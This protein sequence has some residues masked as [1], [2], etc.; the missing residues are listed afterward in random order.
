MSKEIRNSVFLISEG[1]SNPSSGIVDVTDLGIVSSD[2]LDQTDAIRVILEA[3]YKIVRFPAGIYRCRNLYLQD[4]QRIIVNGTIKNINGITFDVTQNAAEGQKNIYI[5]DATT[6]QLNSLESLINEAPDYY[7]YVAF[8]D[9]DY[10]IE[11]G[12]T[13]QVH[14]NSWVSRLTA[15]NKVSKYITV[16]DNIPAM[17]NYCGG[18]LKVSA[19]AKVTVLYNVLEVSAKEDVTILGYGTLDANR[20]NTADVNPVWISGEEGYPDYAGSGANFIECINSRQGKTLTVKD[21]TVQNGKDNIM[22]WYYDGMVWLKNVKSKNAHNKNIAFI[23]NSEEDNPDIQG[24]WEDCDAD[25]SDYEDGFIGYTSADNLT[26]RNCIARN[27]PRYGFAWNRWTSLN[28]YAENLEAYNCGNSFSCNRGG[29][30]DIL[31]LRNLYYE[32]GGYHDKVPNYQSGME[33]RSQI[34]TIGGYENI[35]NLGFITDKQTYGILI[36]FN[37]DINLIWEATAPAKN[38]LCVGN[39]TPPH[40]FGYWLR[41]T[42]D[43]INIV[44]DGGGVL[45]VNNFKYLFWIETGST[46]I[47]IKNCR[48]NDY[49]N[50]GPIDGSATFENNYF[51]DTLYET[52]HP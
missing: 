4:D 49:T 1:T 31:T 2:V 43:C 15:I 36:M 14:H 25:G 11:G 20:A 51:N 27:C 26:I 16:K 32:G 46:G 24:M 42:A 13:G 19:N 37:R 39:L 7:Y 12:G 5:E 50:L 41:I 28:N 38:K 23:V 22:T 52:G 9:D 6:D 33:L 48:F 18:I 40:A 10:T 29:I 17:P 45:E 47:V 30:T 44:I 34:A 35:Y 21:I 8:W 3:D